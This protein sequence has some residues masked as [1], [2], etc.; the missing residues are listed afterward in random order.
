MVVD[1]LLLLPVDCLLPKERAHMVLMEGRGNGG[2]TPV[3]S[4][5]LIILIG[6]TLWTSTLHAQATGELEGRVFDPSGALVSGAMVMLTRDNHVLSVKT[7][8]TGM[9]RLSRIAVGSY[10][11]TV[12]APGFAAFSRADVSVLVGKTTIINASLTIAVQRQAVTVTGQ[13]N[14]VSTAPDQNANAVA[15]KGSDLDALSDDPDALENQLLALAGPAAG[16][17]GGQIYIDG[18]SGGQLPPKSSI[19]EIRINQNPFSAEFARLGYGRIEILTKPGANKLHGSLMVGG[20]DSAFDARNPLVS[21]QPDYYAYYVQT[22]LNGPI[23]RKASYFLSLFVRDTQNQNI[24]DAINPEDPTTRITQA[25]ANPLSS[26][27]LAPRL[28]YQI[29]ENNTLTVRYTLYKADRIGNGVGQ[30]NLASQAFTLHN[31]E[32]T[33][34]IGDT[35]VVNSH[36][37]NETRFQWRRIRNNQVAAFD[38]PTVTVQGAFVDGGN[39]SGVIRDHQDDFELQNISTTS[40]GNHVIRFGTQLRA[41]RDANY[42]TGGQNGNYLFDSLQEY[43]TRQPAQYQMTA[44]TNPL[45]RALLFDGS[46]FYQDDWRIKPD[47]TL[48]YGLRLEGQNHISDHYD[49]APRLSFSWA[50]IHGTKTPPKTV[51]RA[52]Y[53]WFYTR[54]TVPGS[55][56]SLDGTPYIIQAIHDNGK[57]QK[58]YVITNPG[59]YDPT[60]STSPSELQS[61]NASIPI[62]YS[63]DRRFHAALDMEGSIEIDHNFGKFITASVTYLYTRGIHQYLTNNVSAPKFDPETYTIIGTAPSIY[64][65]QFQS[66][67][68][69]KQH[70][71]IVTTNLK[72]KGYSLFGSYI[73]NQARSDT[74]GVDYF[75]SDSSDPGFDYGR[76]SFDIHNRVLIFGNISVPYGISLAP[77]VVYNSGAPYNITIGS[78]LTKNNQFNARPTYGVCGA[79]NVATTKEGCL[80]VDPGGKGEKIVPYGAGTGPSNFVVSLR[81]SKVIGF[82]FKSRRASD[83]ATAGSNRV[84]AP[85]SSEVDARP[86][87]RHASA[88]RKYK[89]TFAAVGSNIFNE[90]NLT[91]PNGVLNSPLFGTSQALAGGAFT[92]PTPGNRS[93]F[94]QTIFTF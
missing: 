83:H 81:A 64:N 21:E 47:F 45:A 62:T 61:G 29:G 82:G 35:Q 89:L 49:W 26:V 76:P 40:F 7:G 19:R 11:L 20:N 33:I 56:S 78:D 85:A 25:I 53:G 34:Q 48:S 51:L 13:G 67:G 37:L 60:K 18:F 24:V 23:T 1:I 22:A 28:D 12:H 94:I 50:P 58:E 31:E 86:E 88:A 71:V 36:L 52:G 41:Y 9:Y 90:V 75:P 10:S 27:Y 15:I 66:G 55:F 38:T 2:R 46:L 84:T 68:I 92:P 54:F 32:N 43:R 65:Y 91:T 63:I 73:Y 8:R 57:N 74:Q 93:I 79:P 69:Y 4:L 17:N 70:E 59:F 14:G 72:Y 6:L 80:D 30:L 16:P 5:W 87:R 77:F 39:N 3:K 42:S 44:I